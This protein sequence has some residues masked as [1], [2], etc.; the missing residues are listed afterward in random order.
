MGFVVVPFEGHAQ[1]EFASPIGFHRVAVENG[2]LQVLS[3]GPSDV[4]NSKVI[5]DKGEGDWASDM[6]E[7]TLC[8][9]TREIASCCENFAELYVG[10]EARFFKSVNR[11]AYLAVEPTGIVNLVSEA[12]FCN[13]FFWYDVNVEAHVL[14]IFEGGIEVHIADIHSHESGAWCGDDAVE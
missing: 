1:I 5:D 10:E 9:G 3:I 2:L 7:E 8:E 13:D 12:V 14:E 4:T 6:F 11:L